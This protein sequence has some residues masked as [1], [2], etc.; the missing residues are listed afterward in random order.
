MKGINNA[1]QGYDNK[2]IPKGHTEGIHS[3]KNQIIIQEFDNPV[4]AF[5]HVKKVYKGKNRQEDHVARL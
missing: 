1:D 3:A 5:G 4:F 2:Y